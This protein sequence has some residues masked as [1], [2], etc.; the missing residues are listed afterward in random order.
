MLYNEFK[1]Y[2][3]ISSNGITL[4][5]LHR[6]SMLFELNGYKKLHKHFYC[7]GFEQAIQTEIHTLKSMNI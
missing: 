7:E 6:D 2:V 5:H 4:I 1:V 3:Q